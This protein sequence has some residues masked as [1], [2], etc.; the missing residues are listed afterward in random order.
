VCR[1]WFLDL[2]ALICI[3]RGIGNNTN[4]SVITNIRF[5]SDIVAIWV[6]RVIRI[7]RGI[8]HIQTIRV[9]RSVRGY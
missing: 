4:N 8:T 1:L 3:F 2:F 6:F 5:I 7:I 9:I